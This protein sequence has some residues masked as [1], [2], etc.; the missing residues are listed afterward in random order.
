MKKT[1]TDKLGTSNE[2]NFVF[3]GTS[4]F[5]IIV[6]DELKRAGFIPEL[7]VTQEDKPKGRHLVLTPPP[8]KVWAQNNKITY[9][10]PTTLKNSEL[11]KQLS[12][13][14]YK[15]FIVASYGKI[16]PQEII[17][18]PEHK[19]LNVHP[20]LLPRLRG[21]SPIQSA[22][23][24]EDETGVTIM[25]LDNKM[26]EGPIVAQKKVTITD[27]P[28]YAN[29]L[30]DVL[31]HEGGKLLVE[32]IPDWIVGKIK[33]KIQD[34]SL[35]TYCKKIDKNDALINLDDPATENLKKIRGY[36]GWPNAYTHFNHLGKNL[37]L[38]IKRARIENGKLILERVIPE[39]KKEMDFED[40]KHG[41]LPKEKTN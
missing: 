28:P 38:I 7:I 37:R 39:G 26:D 34:E 25:R 40:F 19:T 15:L 10:Q 12:V 9:L 36:A 27:W 23:L 18:I 5:S 30:E 20:S 33:E 22:I 35:A 14:G 41:F 13:V 24:E 31:A 6:L 3:L 16:I 8:V 21:P 4:N 17:D 32:M 1:T 29:E 2:M 11:I